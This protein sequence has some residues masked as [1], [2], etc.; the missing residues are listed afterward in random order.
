MSVQ[1]LK[2]QMII[3]VLLIGISSGCFLQ[4]VKIIERKSFYID[5]DAPAVRLRKSVKAEID[6]WDEEKKEWVDGGETILPA[7]GLFKGRKPKDIL[8]EENNGTSD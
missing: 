1:N 2:I 6:I 8:K 4:P 3:L 7:G 5:M